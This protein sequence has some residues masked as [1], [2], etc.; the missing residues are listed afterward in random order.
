MKIILKHIL[1]NIWEKKAR[2]LLIILSLIIATTVFVLNL[3]IPDEIAL[4][5]QETLRSVFG[6][7]DIRLGNEEA[8]SI[9]DIN[10]T[11]E[12]FKYIY[13]TSKDV[14]IGDI[15]AQIFGVEIKDAK[16]MNMLGGDV[17]D[18]KKNEIVIN[19][20]QAEK[21]SFKKGDVIT[22]EVNDKTVEFKI[23][24]VVN[25]KGITALE[26]E[27]PIFIAN[28][29]TINELTENYDKKYNQ[30]Y[31]DVE[32]DEICYVGFVD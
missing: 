22:A 20:K 27:Y 1:R 6:N 17:P 5:H 15:Q 26:S 14:F 18:L 28:I 10:T 16:D 11:D 24:E 7:A 30:I 12:K 19:S 29:E 23:V 2:S 9:D 4:K 32:N 8:F 21:H 3:T 25:K 13:L 31:I